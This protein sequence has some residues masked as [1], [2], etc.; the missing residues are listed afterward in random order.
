MDFWNKRTSLVFH[1]D[2]MYVYFWDEF[3]RT[4]EISST[5]G[6]FGN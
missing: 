3:E 1:G 2:Y 6:K 5:K 4:R